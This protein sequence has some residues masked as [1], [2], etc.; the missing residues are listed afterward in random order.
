[1]NTAPSPSPNWRWKVWID[2][3]Q[4]GTFDNTTE[5][6]YNSGA[7]T[8]V[9]LSANGNIQIPTAIPIG[10]TRMR[11]GMKWGSSDFTACTNFSYGEVEDYCVNIMDDPSALTIAP[12]APQLFAYPNP[13]N[14]LLNISYRTGEDV[15]YTIYDLTGRSLKTGLI[16]NG[17][18]QVD[19]SLLNAGMYIL[20][21]DAN[22]GQV[23]VVKN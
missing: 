6:V 16:K 8:T 4:D 9:T 21:L 23:K 22:K 7:I 20:K 13:T 18:E 10:S 12:A 2:Y 3:N 15:F 1:M 19:I 5:L 17:F 11:V 14:D